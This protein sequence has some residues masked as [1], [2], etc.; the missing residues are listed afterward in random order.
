MDQ[1][2]KTGMMGEGIDSI[3]NFCACMVN[4]ERIT[5]HINR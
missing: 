2:D 4:K 1:A 3:S 5:I